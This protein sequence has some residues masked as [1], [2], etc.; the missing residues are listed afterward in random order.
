MKKILTVIISL[1]FSL[2]AFKGLDQRVYKKQVPLLN[3]LEIHR[4]D[5][6]EEYIFTF[7]LNDEVNPKDVQGARMFFH[8][9]P[10]KGQLELLPEKRKQ[11]GFDNWDFTVDLEDDGTFVKGV[12]S[13]VD[14]YDSLGIGIYIKPNG[15]KVQNRSRLNL[16][17]IN[18]KNGNLKFTSSEIKELKTYNSY[19][20]SEMKLKRLTFTL[21][22]FFTVGAVV[23]LEMRLSYTGTL[24]LPG[25]IYIIGG[26]P[27]EG[28]VSIVALYYLLYGV[29]VWVERLIF[30]ESD[31]LTRSMVTVAMAVTIQKFPIRGFDGSKFLLGNAL[32]IV[33]LL[34]GLYLHRKELIKYA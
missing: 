22:S 9:T 21:V 23:F 13:K 19:E 29:A 6:P 15:E 33:F 8:G 3:S 14:N 28:I 31:V 34:F 20:T 18:F 2:I 26:I 7:K 30:K 27:K 17:N 11:H 12:V 32:G 24:I 10:A 25:L 4:G 16:A 5:K 1:V